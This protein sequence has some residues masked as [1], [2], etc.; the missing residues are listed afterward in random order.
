MHG[1]GEF[2]Q[3]ARANLETQYFF[4]GSYRYAS[5]LRAFVVGNTFAHH[6][7][8]CASDNVLCA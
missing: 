2:R 8:L 3:R 4:N 1:F 7:Q 6:Q 5:E